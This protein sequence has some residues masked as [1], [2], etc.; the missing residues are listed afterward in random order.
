MSCHGVWEM[1]GPKGVQKGTGVSFKRVVV[2][3]TDRK[4]D[5]VL[6]RQV[7]VDSLVGNGGFVFSQVM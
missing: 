3:Q 4:A 1:V 2:H 5:C 7:T 6:W